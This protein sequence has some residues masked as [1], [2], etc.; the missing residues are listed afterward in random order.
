MKIKKIFSA[1]NFYINHLV[2]LKEPI[3]KIGWPPEFFGPF[4]FE[5]WNK[6]VWFF[7]PAGKKCWP[8]L[9]GPI[10]SGFFLGQHSDMP[11]GGEGREAGREL[12]RSLALVTLRMQFPRYLTTIHRKIAIF[13]NYPERG[14]RLPLKIN[15]LLPVPPPT[16]QTLVVVVALVR[17]VACYSR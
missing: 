7:W 4:S 15:Q 2:N 14:F 11:G 3:E 16:A 5:T 9:D 13:Y 12:G 17:K 10:W 8:F 1:N 6:K